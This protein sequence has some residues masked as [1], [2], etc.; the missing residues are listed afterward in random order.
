MAEFHRSASERRGQSASQYLDE[1]AP[2]FSRFG[3]K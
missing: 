1:D 2:T 3:S